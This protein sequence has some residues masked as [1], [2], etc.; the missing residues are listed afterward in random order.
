MTPR[1]FPC[2]R[3]P[4]REGCAEKRVFAE[5]VR[6]LGARSV[7]FDCAKLGAELRRGRRI[8][9]ETPRLVVVDS[10]SG[11]QARRG[12]YHDTATINYVAPSYRFTCVVDPGQHSEG[13]QRFRRLRGHHR[14]VRFLD[15]PDGV[16]CKL[17]ELQRDGAC[18][19]GPD[20]SCSCKQWAD[21]LAE[22]KIAAARAELHDRLGSAAE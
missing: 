2:F 10:Y 16:F 20:M 17:G 15:E 22:D 18:D 8:V 13:K 9:V 7:A 1:I 11:E 21:M 6:G 14:I 5:K 12:S 19:T 4:L 3:C